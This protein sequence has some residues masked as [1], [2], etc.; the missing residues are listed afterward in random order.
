L[1]DNTLL[2]TGYQ[3]LGCAVIKQARDDFYRG[4]DRRPGPKKAYTYERLRKKLYEIK[5]Q[6]DAGLFL[7]KRTDP[8]AQFWFRLAGLS[9]ETYRDTYVKT[10]D[11]KR[12]IELK[13]KEHNVIEKMKRLMILNPK[14]K[15]HRRAA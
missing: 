8:C 2:L 12:Y 11:Q 5:E 14:K 9:M 7:M 4:R 6:T 13:R 3:G 15:Q 10:K 1:T